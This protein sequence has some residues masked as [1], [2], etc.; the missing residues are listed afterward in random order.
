MQNNVIKNANKIKTGENLKIQKIG[1]KI[2]DGDTLNSIAKKFGL[3]VEI[4]KK[5]NN[6][7]N[8]DIIKKGVMIEIPGVIYTV[9]SG[10]TLSAIAKEVG[11]GTK[12]LM[13]INN[14]TSDKIIPNQKL[15]IIYTKCMK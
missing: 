12:E 15:K 11:I 7:K 14:L 9:K 8:E 6:I 3:T 2:K 10:Q 5:I 4:L 13:Q 1:Y